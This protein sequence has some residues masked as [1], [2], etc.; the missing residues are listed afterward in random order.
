MKNI[1]YSDYDKISDIMDNIF[2]ALVLLSNAAASD[3]GNQ[4][5]DWLIDDSAY[6]AVS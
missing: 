1:Q 2:L 6:K 3:N 5:A 4:K